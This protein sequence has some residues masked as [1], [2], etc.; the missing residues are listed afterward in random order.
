MACQTT[1]ILFQHVRVFD[2]LQVIPSTDVL[3]RDGRIENIGQDPKD[4]SAQIVDGTGKTLLPGLID[5]HVHVHR[6]ESLQQALTFGVTTEFDMAMPRY[7]I[8]ELKNSEISSMADFW[9]AGE[10]ATAPGGH[11]TEYGRIIP[12][13]TSPKEAQAWVDDRIAEGSA[14]IKIVYGD[15]SEYGSRRIWPTLSKQTMTGYYRRGA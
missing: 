1:P 6:A 2:G 15:A 12:T 14:Y 13:I 11:G 8:S 10:L 9:S 5:S 3:I 7:R 4:P